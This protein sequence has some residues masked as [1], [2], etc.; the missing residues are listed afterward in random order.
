M[1]RNIA[2]ALARLGLC[3]P[4]L[5]SAVGHDHAGEGL[6]KQ[7]KHAGV[8]VSAMVMPSS[9]EVGYDVGTAT[10]AAVHDHRYVIF[11]SEITDWICF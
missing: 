5:V 11:I 2:E 3:H 9:D 8:D 6:L 7:S 10:Y 1:G 4:L